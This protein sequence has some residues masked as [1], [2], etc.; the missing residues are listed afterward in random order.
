[1]N[2]KSLQFSED[3]SLRTANKSTSRKIV[4]LFKNSFKIAK[5]VKDVF[6]ILAIIEP[7]FGKK[8]SLAYSVERSHIYERVQLDEYYQNILVTHL[9]HLWN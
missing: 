1:M 8:N 3:M 6:K 7:I 4:Y 9:Y 5:T 2:L